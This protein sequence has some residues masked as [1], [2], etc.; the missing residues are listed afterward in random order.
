MNM[1]LCE[2]FPFQK[3]PNHFKGGKYGA[4]IPY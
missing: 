1:Q 3:T 4:D 2:Q